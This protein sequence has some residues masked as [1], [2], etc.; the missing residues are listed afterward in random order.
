MRH[1]LATFDFEPLDLPSA[2]L[3]G[4]LP[5]IGEFLAMLAGREPEFAALLGQAGG[6]TGAAP[7]DPG[8]PAL[9]ERF[10]RV[11]AE[12]ADDEDAPRQ[13]T[14]FDR[15]LCDELDRLE[16]LIDDNRLRG[17][18]SSDLK[19]LAGNLRAEPGTRR[20]LDRTARKCEAADLGDRLSPE[21]HTLLFPRAKRRRR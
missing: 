19:E 16:E 13:E 9:G 1:A 6:S 8:D 21:L 15:D 2:V 4:G 12:D 7:P 18:P 11:L 3:D 10:R 14:L 17:A 5:S 20:E